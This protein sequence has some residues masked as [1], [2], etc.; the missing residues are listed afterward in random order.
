MVIAFLGLGSNL[1][2]CKKNITE[3]LCELEK[4]GNKILKVSSIYETEPYGYKKQPKFLN[5]VVKIKTTL[6]PQE[7]LTVCKKIEKK[8]GRKKT[9]KWGPR[10]IDIDILF[11]GN[12]KIQK[13]HLK[14]PH[15]ELH[16]REFVLK[17]LKEVTKQLSE[18]VFIKNYL[19]TSVNCSIK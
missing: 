6:E 2:D 16:K 1:G 19:K 7:L 15:P 3:A 8:L 18:N 5:A 11:Y 10:T 17:P 12:K 9:F 14:I 13:K 4:N